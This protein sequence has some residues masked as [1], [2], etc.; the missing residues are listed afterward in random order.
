[1]STRE[2]YPRNC[3]K[4]VPAEVHIEG[5]RAGAPRSPPTVPVRPKRTSMDTYEGRPRKNR[6]THRACRHRLIPRRS[7]A[8][9]HAQLREHEEAPPRASST[10]RPFHAEE[11]VTT[12]HHHVSSAKQARVTA[13]RMANGVGPPTPRT[14][15]G[16]VSV[17]HPCKQS[18]ASTNPRPK[19]NRLRCCDG[20][21][22]LLSSGV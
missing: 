4:R 20:R 14:K 21:E 3:T 10:F 15:E 1:M 2:G 12:R 11:Q 6:Y 9:A 5:T 17:T 13:P 22:P 7:P 8:Q 16:F 19:R 18:L